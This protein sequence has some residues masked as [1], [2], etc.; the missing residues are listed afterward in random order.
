M[1][2]KTWVN[3]LLLPKTDNFRFDLLSRQIVSFLNRTTGPILDKSRL[4][5]IIYPICS[6]FTK[7]ALFDIW[8][9]IARDCQAVEYCE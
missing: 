5:Q 9:K 7:L 4:L 8:E 3:D 2:L 6:Y 1:D